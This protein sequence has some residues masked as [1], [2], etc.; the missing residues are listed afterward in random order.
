[1]NPDNDL[2][3]L[4][5]KGVDI[6]KQ[7]DAR[8]VYN[9]IGSFNAESIPAK[10]HYAAGWILYYCLHQAD[11]KEILP[12]K[13]MLAEY[14]GLSTPRPHKLHSMI[15]LEAMRLYKDAKNLEFN[16]LSSGKNQTQD[17]S[18]KFSITKFINLWNLDNL[19]PGDWKRKE[20]EGKQM[21]STVEKLITIIVDELDAAKERPSEQF[22]NVMQKALA[23]YPDSYNLLVQWASLLIAVGNQEEAK[24][25]VRKA[26]LLAPGKFHLWSMLGSATPLKQ[27]P[28][29]RMALFAK[30]L[31]SPGQEQFKGRIRLR[32]AEIWLERGCYAQGKYELDKVKEIYGRQN[33]HLPAEHTR[34][35][36]Q[37]PSDTDTASPESM[38]R[39]LIPMAEEYLYSSLPAIEARKTYHKISEKDSTVAWRVTDSAGTNYWIQPRRFG[40]SPDLPMSTPLQI[41]IYNGKVVDAKI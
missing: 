9:A 11:D 2:T 29:L 15:L 22:V 40:I 7:G 8:S 23:E 33:W 5:S 26:L 28:R 31:Y 4:I 38:Y 21:G 36:A 6:A 41:R 30:A 13:R 17:S 39:K 35:A 24:E 10:S 20:F 1:M 3:A 37:I 27:E 12:R 16:A 14:L 32:L 19:R 25:Y 18:R 34:L